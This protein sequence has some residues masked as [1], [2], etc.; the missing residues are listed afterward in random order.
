M[1]ALN[2]HGTPGNSPPLLE[3]QANQGNLGGRLCLDGGHGAQVAT[4]VSFHVSTH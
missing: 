2:T 3:T 4:F 1:A